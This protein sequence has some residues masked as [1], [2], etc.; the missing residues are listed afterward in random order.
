MQIKLVMRWR[1]AVIIP[2]D[3]KE[4]DR[5]KRRQGRGGRGPLPRSPWG[6]TVAQLLW[7]TF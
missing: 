3:N 7:K 2:A 6:C 4:T 1:H 5:A